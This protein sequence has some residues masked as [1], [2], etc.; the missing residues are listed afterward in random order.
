MPFKVLSTDAFEK[1]IQMGIPMNE[2]DTPPNLEVHQGKTFSC[3]CGGVHSF[4]YDDTP[5]FLDLG[6][7]K[8]CVLVRK[9]GWLNTI[10]LKSLFS[11]KIKTLYSCRWEQGEDRYGF[12]SDYPR[13]DEVI[14][15]YL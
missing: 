5:A 1:K 4:N 6:L 10:Q 3:P 13:F 2:V 11:N 15:A 9:C 14:K 12:Q 7:F 8:V